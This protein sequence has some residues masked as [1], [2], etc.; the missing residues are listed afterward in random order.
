MDSTNGRGR[1]LGPCSDSAS[2]NS[3]SRRLRNDISDK[4]Y[5]SYANNQPKNSDTGFMKNYSFSDQQKMQHEGMKDI[6]QFYKKNSSNNGFSI[7]SILNQT[8]S[9]I[10]NRTSSSSPESVSSDFLDHTPHYSYQQFFTPPRNSEH[11]LNRS[12]E[13]PC[14]AERLEDSSDD[15][16]DVETDLVSDQ[17]ELQHELNAEE[18]KTNE[19]L[20][21]E[22]INF[23]IFLYGHI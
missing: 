20:H 15:E 1:P 4:P 12:A 14:V 13:I 10:K 3:E 11:L 23:V 6:R 5:K 21:K 7:D 19:R 16:I 18:H 22:G 17:K 8:T 9:D 2:G